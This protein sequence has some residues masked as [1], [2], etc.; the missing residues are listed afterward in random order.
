M[1]SNKKNNLIFVVGF[2]LLVGLFAFSNICLAEKKPNYV[3][4]EFII[5]FKGNEK[6]YKF[7]TDEKTDII[8]I[9]N[10]YKNL[11]EVEYIEPNY[12]LE[13]AAFP[14]DPDLY[15]Q[16]Y[17]F[18]IK[19]KDGWSDELLAREVDK[20]N[21]KPIIAI[22]DSG[23]YIN[24][25]DLK[26]KIWI[27]NDEL[28]NDKVDNDK[29]GYVDDINGWDFINNVSD[30]NPKFNTVYLVEAVNHGTIVAGIAAATVNNS[31]GMSG[32]SWFGE[33]MP[34]RILDENGEGDV[35]SVVQAIDYA[36]SNGA[37]VI[38]MSFI[39]NN[40]SPSLNEAIRR[41]NSQGVVVV[42]AAGNT[43][44]SV[45]GTDMNLV[46]SYPV[47]YDGNAGENL[48]IG[49]GSIG[50]NLV[51]S[52]FSN[53]GAC[54]DVMAPGEN[55]HSTLFY[56][57]NN[58]LFGYF[59]NGNMSGTSLAVPMVSATAATMKALR[60]NLTP[61]EITSYILS[62]AKD[63]NSYNVNY[64]GKLGA[65]LLDVGK[66]IQ[67]ILTKP[68][69][70]Q[71]LSKQNSYII[72][73]LGNGSFPQVKIIKSDGTIFKSFFAYAV[74]F[75]GEI[76]ALG[77]DVNGDGKSEII[78]APGSGG[79]PH[80]RVLNI[81]G[82]LVS[83]FFAYDKYNRSG[84]NLAIADV[85]GD[86]I[87]EIITAPGKG[88]KSEVKV[89]DY[90]GKLITSFLAYENNWTS[91]VKV[92][93]GDINRDGQAEI[94]TGTGVGSA[95]LVKVFD[96]NGHVISQFYA[97]NQN[98]K[99]GVN[100]ACGD[101]HGDAQPEIVT[102]LGK[103]SQPIVKVFTF[104]GYNLSTFFA[105]EPNY[106]AGENIFVGD[107]N[108]DGKGEILA[109]NGFGTEAKL[110]IFDQS[111]SLINSLSVNGK[112]NGGVRLGTIRY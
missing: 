69:P 41:A 9:I 92:S 23:V 83:Q 19:A 75:K 27:N 79:G 42:A 28:A 61:K 112:N 100:V 55:I 37:D 38:N 44:P 1:L 95:P 90:K 74:G 104:E 36:I 87:D 12:K 103:G 65:G 59:Y 30:P 46:K 33:I 68:A 111:G 18:T 13:S 64:L 17:L 76:T 99:S 63:I 35:Y 4:G 29:N 3:L 7:S 22:L 56:Q 102:S 45:N 81:D 20:N 5:K 70:K 32:V 94:I 26:E 62:N 67:A 85:N 34:L 60:P 2:F 86:G 66:T 24:H 50:T 47:C 78:T 110:R 96:L 89:F 8:S 16:W 25:P 10:K 71:I 52:K 97:Y 15:S 107:V 108:N 73:A 57:K 40:E 72:A 14:N 58:Q 43:D 48:V 6:I 53:Y 84:V 31:V 51:K 49:V 80:I 11:S 77:G 101:V 106:F 82:Q 109:G 39:G 88:A 21:R 54:V 91:G 105:N 93:A 98:S